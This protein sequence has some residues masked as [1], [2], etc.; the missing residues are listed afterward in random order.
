MPKLGIIGG[1]GLYHMEGLKNSQWVKIDTPFGSPSDEFL[2][3]N[4][5][6]MDIVFLPRHGRGHRLLPC[7]LTTPLIYTG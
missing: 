7:E 6:A 2:C 3:A 4:L 1:S 5:S